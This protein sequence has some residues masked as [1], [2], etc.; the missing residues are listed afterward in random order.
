MNNNRLRL[1]TRPLSKLAAA[2]LACAAG[3]GALTSAVAGSLHTRARPG[4]FARLVMELL[5]AMLPGEQLDITGYR[6]DE[7]YLLIAAVL[8]ALLLLPLPLLLFRFS[9]RPGWEGKTALAGRYAAGCCLA[10]AASLVVAAFFYQAEEAWLLATIP[11]TLGAVACAA[12]AAMY[13]LLLSRRQPVLAMTPLWSFYLAAAAAALLIPV[14]LATA[15]ASLAS[16]REMIF[17][18]LPLFLG[19]YAAVS[20]S[21]FA[22]REE[23]RLAA[24]RKI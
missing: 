10:F 11:Y 16:D 18:G 7:P 5:E 13:L 2:G 6:L 1:H 8:T 20:L 19:L 15:V 21:A 4:D 17:F 22:Y 23:V 9:L 14:F 24:D 12:V 3:A